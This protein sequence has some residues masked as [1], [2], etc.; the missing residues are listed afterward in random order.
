MSEDNLG[1]WTVM[2]SAAPPFP[3]DRRPPSR[4]SPP[5][6][7]DTPEKTK[8]KIS[9]LLHTGKFKIMASLYKFYKKHPSDLPEFSSSP[10]WLLGMVFLPP[11]GQTT[12]EEG[13]LPPHVAEFI[14][15]FSSLLWFSYR[16]DFPPIGSSSITSDIGWGCMLRTGQ[17]ML[18]QALVRH[19][20]GKGWRPSPR[21]KLS[22]FS[23]YRQIVRWFSDSPLPQHPYSIHNIVRKN[24]ANSRMHGSVSQDR[25]EEWYAP[26]KIAKVL[27]CL[28]RRHLGRTLSV[29]VAEDGM[30]YLDKIIEGCDTTRSK[31]GNQEANQNELHPDDGEVHPPSPSP[32][33]DPNDGWRSLIIVVPV[34]LGVESLN[35]VYVETIQEFFRL[36]QSIGILGGRPKKSFYF[37]GYQDESMLYLDPH[38]VHASVRPDREFSP[39]SYHCQVPLK[40]PIVSID[41]TLA[42]CFYC[43]DRKDFETLAAHLASSS[44]RE[45]VIHVAVTRPS[46]LP[47][48]DDLD[49]DDEQDDCVPDAMADLDIADDI[50]IL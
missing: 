42:F 34:R 16:K 46:Y 26:T 1:G 22:P 17:M 10:I 11:T 44:R 6:H 14:E 24:R 28:V 12:F 3:E 49:D 35:P 45:K 47:P 50:L 43:H 33:T 7:E 40:M 23:V 2:E 18:A 31:P 39:E 9:S 29:Y 15:N 32:T 19:L 27:Q 21:D 30:L 20:L 25:I 38:F 41:P 36:P 8:Q 4:H 48:L 37:V 5:P 13:E